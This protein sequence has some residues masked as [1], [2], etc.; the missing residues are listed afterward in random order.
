MGGSAVRHV[1]GSHVWYGTVTGGHVPLDGPG[2]P[3][4]LPFHE[5]DNVVMSPHVAG[6]T[7]DVFPAQVR[8]VAE[9]LRRFRAGEALH[10]VYD[11]ELGY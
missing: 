2:R 3:Y 7:D 8:F 6:W 4:H 11:Y 9:N 5:R 1:A 10:H